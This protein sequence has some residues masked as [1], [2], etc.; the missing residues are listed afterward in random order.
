[1][2]SVIEQVIEQV[3][4]QVMEPV[5]PQ[6]VVESQIVKSNIV[7]STTLSSPLELPDLTNQL[8]SLIQP[9]QQIQQISPDLV[10]KP[11]TDR[12]PLCMFGFVGGYNNCLGFLHHSVKPIVG[13][14]KYDFSTWSLFPTTVS[15]SRELALKWSN[16]FEKRKNF[17]GKSVIIFFHLQMK[18]IRVEVKEKL[19][20]TNSI[21]S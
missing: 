1:M 18:T 16:S 21:S 11:S 20:G 5:E 4:E 19:A 8:N 14:V 6:E 13:V 3:M 15:Q 10:C 12:K 7:E 9:I 17:I 2:S